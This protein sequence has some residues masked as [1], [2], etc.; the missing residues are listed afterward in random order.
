MNLV[1][2]AIESMTGVIIKSPFFEQPTTLE[3]FPIHSK[4]S[5][6][7]NR[8]ALL[9]GANGSGK[10]TIAQGFREYIDSVIPRSVDLTPI[11]GSS[12]IKITPSAKPEKLF[13]FD[14]TYITSNIKL[15]EDGLGSIVLFGP[16]VKLDR[17]IEENEEAV[18]KVRREIS[19]Q[20]ETYNQFLDSR[21][22]ASPKYWLDLITKKLQEDGGW[23]ENDGIRIKKH[24]IKTRVTSS[25]IERIGAVVPKADEPTSRKEFEDIIAIYDNTFSLSSPISP[26]VS[27]VKI[28]YNILSVVRQQLG[29]KP[30]SPKLSLREQA[31]LD[32]LGMSALISAKGYLSISSNTIC[33]QC[34]QPISERHRSDM[35]EKI[36]RIFNK[37]LD[38][39]CGELQ[40]MLIPE[41]SSNAYADYA[42]VDAELIEKITSQIGLTNLA[43]QQH[44]KVVNL[45]IADP[46]SDISYDDNILVGENMLKLN[47]LLSKL[48]NKRI[49]HNQ[50]IANRKAATSRLLLLNDTLGHYSIITDYKRMVLQRDLQESAHIK[51]AALNKELE[52]LLGERKNLDAQRRDFKLAVEQINQSLSYIFYSDKKLQL[53][54]GEDQV[55]YLKSNGK[56]V[57]PNRISC[58]ER[59][60]LALSYFFAEIAKETEVRSLYQNDMLLIIDDPVS[61]FDVENRVGIMSFLRFKFSQILTACSTTKL[62]VMTHDISVLFDLRKAME[63][64]SPDCS[65]TGKSAEYVSF[66]LENK[67]L[68]QFMPKAHNE[69]T[70]LMQIVYEY[71]CNPAEDKDIVIGNTMRR[72][73]EAF[74]TFSFKE[75]IEKVSINPAV[76][77]LVED[78]HK[79]EYFQNSMY[80]LVLHTESH[81]QE[82]VQGAPET[83]FYS[84]VS[85]LEKQRTAKDV[86][87][88]MYCVNPVHVLAHLPNAKET[89]ETWVSSI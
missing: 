11:A 4:A 38:D 42:D 22:L 69:Y 89:I 67:K 87:C 74:S 86:L 63:E 6:K 46:L 61:S 45:K 54:L 35:L 51:L 47:D 48:E 17:E 80:R 41:I 66:H 31:L 65:R 1:S 84:H 34:L 30:E 88:F 77:S 57:A 81:F 21:N 23:A 29:K 82:A 24:Q 19:E 13:V 49:T 43:I 26:A 44:N 9:Y 16:Q 39:F 12:K 28:P 83:S 71:G 64:I 37:Q 27:C 32:T 59:N 53:E 62:L 2:S 60:A 33:S 76:L 25:E 70:K 52:V 50:M 73:L 10:S 3:F 68:L 15:R 14:E 7:Q 85:K 78:P 79:R 58:G 5:T 18:K 55:Y 40:S 72:L 20:S 36:E 56:L 8:V 75:G